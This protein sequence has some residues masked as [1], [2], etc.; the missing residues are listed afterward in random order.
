MKSLL[1]MTWVEAKLFLREP[2]S[3]FFT[4]IFPLLMLLIFGAI[5]GANPVPGTDSTE[6]AI[7]ALI[8]AFTGMSIGIVGL[9]PVTITMAT[10]RE[11]GILRR[12]RTTP[13][14]PLMI[15]AAQVVVVF[16]MTAL[17]VL[18]LMIAGKLVYHV[19]FTGNALSL[20][21]GFTFCSLSFFGTGF[22]L[23][24]T[25]PTARTA[26]IV[27]MVLMYPM[28]ILSG[29]G[30][31]RELMPAAVLKISNFLP[32]TYV[33]NLLRGLWFGESWGQHLLDVGV[34]AVMLIAGVLISLKTFRW[35]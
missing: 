26:Q 7:G 34:L 30:W 13:A 35:E 2:A 17:G 21:A 10:Y 22:V 6:A 25:M 19:Q 4:L 29:A 31:P 27:A 23:A 20:A 1:K 33:V 28:L 12:L 15:M 24:G 32:L 3:A 5:Y 11:N 14:S 16:V 18:L 9:M 8:P